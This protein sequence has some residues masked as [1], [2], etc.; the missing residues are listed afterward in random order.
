MVE[1]LSRVQFE[2]GG[3]WIHSVVEEANGTD[4]QRQSFI[5]RVMKGGRLIMHNMRH[6]HSTPITTEQYL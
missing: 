6:I 1:S 5:I 2:D 3:P 4:H